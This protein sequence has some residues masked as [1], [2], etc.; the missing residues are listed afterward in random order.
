[1]S[2][3]HRCLLVLMLLAAGCPRGWAASSAENRAL[4]A[5]RNSFLATVWDRAEK[6]FADF[7]QEFPTSTLVPEAILFQA[8]AR[9][10][11]TNYAGAI[12]LL[13]AN[14]STAGSWADQ[15]YFWLAE[16]YY[17]KGDYLTARDTFAKVVRDFPGS[18]RRLEAAIQEAATLAKMLDWG[19]VVV[20]LSQPDG[21]FQSTAR[22]N[23]T[24][25]LISRGYLLLSEAQ[26]AQ[27]NYP[28]AEASLQPL[29]KA[30]LKP[31]LDWQRQFL[32][33]R[34]QLAAGKTADALQSATTLVAMATD[35]AQQGLR[36]ES[37]AFQ[38]EILE[39]LGRAD[40]AMATY[41]NNLAEGVPEERQRQALLK[42]AELSLATN[43]VAEAAQTLTHFLDQFPT[44]P[45]ADL[46]LLT[47]GELRLRQHLAALGTNRLDVTATNAPAYVALQQAVNALNTLLD[48][49]PRSSLTGKAE[50]DLGWCQWR[51]ENLPASQAAFEKAVALLPPASLDRATAQFKLADAQFQQRNF[52]GALTNYEGVAAQAAASAGIRTNYLESALY[53]AVR[54]AL[55]AGNLSAATNDAARL[56]DEFPQGFHTDSAILLAG[57]EISREGDPRLAREI[58]SEFTNRIPNAALL[59]QLRLAIARTYEQQEDWASASREYNGWLASYTN[60]SARAAVEYYAAHAYFLQGDDT[61]ALRGF[62]NLVARFPES[63]FAPIARLWVGDYYL[64]QGG[65]TN[66]FE[67]EF[68]YQALF[69]NKKAPPSDL[70]YEAIMMAGRVAV[71]RQEWS[72]A[73]NYFTNLTSDPKCPT[74]LKIEAMFAYGSVLMSLDTGETNKLAN[75]EEAIKVFK[76]IAQSYPGTR[77]AALAWGEVGNC[78]LQFAQYDDAIKAYS[79]VTNAPQADVIA[80][81]I[82]KVGLA[83]VFEKQ[84]SQADL[85]AERK[86]ALLG[87]ALNLYLDVFWDKILRDDEKPDLF[88]T[89]KA[90][91]EAGRVAEALQQWLPAVRIYEGLQ[92]MLPVL[93]SKFE[94]KRLKAQAHLSRANK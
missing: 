9:L 56:L 41:T 67:A 6:E 57:Q 94:E 16:T 81:A 87:D 58:F 14:V 49:F 74:G 91:L 35:S 48:K 42:I 34:I 79:E 80:R 33:C 90:G 32:L 21:I 51:L 8:E 11:Q 37:V 24:A 27:G 1:M 82:A 77:S 18:S 65:T 93:N 71:A 78:Y 38:A 86:N 20:R 83:T 61:N 52:A 72:D 45:A 62:T 4:N 46:A 59:P 23:G 36:A 25:E 3:F 26:F 40:E 69:Q 89:K 22:T 19:Q 10:Q 54:S 15:Y 44:A 70:S 47:V 68:N 85:P 84:A 60:N 63:E 88:W 55:N 12:E 73:R 30:A 92:T 7:V 17:R 2:V 39:R 76:Q 31:Q 43:R 13:T 53:Q 66:L 50:M 75:Y 5:A 29:S 64:R 28:A